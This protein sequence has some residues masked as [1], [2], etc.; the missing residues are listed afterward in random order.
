MI[1]AF[2]ETSLVDWDGKLTSVVFFDKCNFRCPFCQNWELIID[3]EKFPVIAWDTIKKKLQKKKGWVDGVVLT[4]GEPLV[5]KQEV[6]DLCT[7]IRQLNLAIKIDTNGAYP[8]ILQDFINR[9]LVDYVAMDVKA[10]LDKSY[11]VATGT[12]VNIENIQKSID[13]LLSNQVAYEFRTTCVPGIINEKTIAEIGQRIRNAQKWA[14]QAYVPDNAYKQ[15]YRT[16]LGTDYL[17]LLQN[18]LQIAKKYVD[19]TILRGKVG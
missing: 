2:V 16:K 6:L 12:N 14:L 3:P 4:G 17:P 5:D 9:N 19:N 18:L 1:R 10:P 8:A 15:E 11:D 7:K 13:I